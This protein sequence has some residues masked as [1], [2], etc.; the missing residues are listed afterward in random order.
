MAIVA[1]RG[2]L[3]AFSSA[4]QSLADSDR[5]PGLT[6][7]RLRIVLVGLVFWLF[8]CEQSGSSGE[9]PVAAAP[10]HGIH[11]EGAF[12]AAPESRAASSGA[13]TQRISPETLDFILAMEEGQQAMNAEVDTERNQAEQELQA[14]LVNLQDMIRGDGPR[15]RR[16]RELLAASQA[17]WLKYATAQVALEWPDPAAGRYG[18]VHPMCHAQRWT[19]LIQD[20]IKQLRTMVTV[21]EGDVCL[22]AWPDDQ[23]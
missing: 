23:D 22:P 16:A 14:L 17:A 11:H 21:D 7:S 20:R 9:R 15:S 12:A 3:A 8:A 18:S 2:G 4:L 1:V 6:G 19:V 10:A 5:L 13:R